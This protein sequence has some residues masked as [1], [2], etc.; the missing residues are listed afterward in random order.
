M[1]N[2]LYIIAILITST[3]Y[4]QDYVS[5]KKSDTI[6]V[7]FKGKKNERKSI[8]P[9]TKYNYDDRVYSFFIFDQESLDLYHRKYSSYE[10]SVANIVSDVKVV[11]KSFIKKNKAKIITPKFIKKK[12]LCKIVA[13]ILNHHRVIYIIDC[14]EKKENKIKLYEVEVGTICRGDG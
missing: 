13:E 11:N 9:Q 12:N 6:Y 4:S 2:I 10:N 5:L 7:L 8:Q 3:T 1:K 14:T